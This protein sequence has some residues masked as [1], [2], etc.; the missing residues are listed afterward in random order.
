MRLF[1]QLAFAYLQYDIMVS[2]TYEKIQVINQILFISECQLIEIF[3][4]TLQC[5][6]EREKMGLLN[7][8][9]ISSR[10]SINVLFALVCFVVGHNKLLPT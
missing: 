3:A 1:F 8:L 2:N 4:Q 10:F 7:S 5:G 6:C 9:A